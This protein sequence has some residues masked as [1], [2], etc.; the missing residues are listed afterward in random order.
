MILRFCAC[1]VLSIGEVR[2]LCVLER[3][4][5]STRQQLYGRCRGGLRTPPKL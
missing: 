4:K 3:L 5:P 1:N 2:R